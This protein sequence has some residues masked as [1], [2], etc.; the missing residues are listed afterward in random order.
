MSNYAYDWTA[1]M[2][3]IRDPHEC[4]CISIHGQLTSVISVK[5]QMPSL[6]ELVQWCEEGKDLQSNLGIHR[7]VHFLLLARW[8]TGI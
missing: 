1:A 2:A 7:P 3:T 6:I 8:Y 5:K 4:S